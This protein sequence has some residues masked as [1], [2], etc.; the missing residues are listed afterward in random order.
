MRYTP[1]IEEKISREYKEG[2][3]A[4]EIALELGVPERSVISKLSCLGIYVRKTYLTKRGEV[5]IRKEEYIQRISKLLDIDVDLLE[6]LEKVTKS[7]LVLLEKQIIAK[8]R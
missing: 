1:E 5:P 8:A 7:A 4:K 2:R 3:T 6:S